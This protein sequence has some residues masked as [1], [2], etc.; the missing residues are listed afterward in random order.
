MS[1]SMQTHFQARSSRERSR[2]TARGRKALERA[3]SGQF[4]KRTFKRVDLRLKQRS[5]CVGTKLGSNVEFSRWTTNVT[6][7][8]ID[9][10]VV[11]SAVQ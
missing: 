10:F 8:V 6:E 4:L 7:D 11:R 2:N 9:P 1:I 5:A 3:R